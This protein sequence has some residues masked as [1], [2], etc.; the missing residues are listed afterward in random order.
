LIK[1]KEQEHK[2]ELEEK[3]KI[4]AIKEKKHGEDLQKIQNKLL[5]AEERIES[6]QKEVLTSKEKANESFTDGFTIGLLVGAPAGITGTLLIQ[7]FLSPP[8]NTTQPRIVYPR[9][10]RP[11]INAIPIP[12][13]MMTQ[14]DIDYIN[15]GLNPI[16]NISGTTCSGTFNNNYGEIH[17][18]GCD[19]TINQQDA[20]I[21]D[22]QEPKI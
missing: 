19:A 20:E 16:T 3:N 17:N 7:K 15:S 4:I 13:E 18:A 2:R 8:S 1:T 21:I 14:S 12:P 22:N 11:V 10:A 5:D 6:L 9:K